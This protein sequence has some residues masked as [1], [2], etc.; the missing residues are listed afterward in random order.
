MRNLINNPSHRS[1]KFSWRCQRISYHDSHCPHSQH[2]GTCDLPRPAIIFTLCVGKLA[3]S[4]SQQIHIN[5]FSQLIV[6]T[7]IE[8]KTNSQ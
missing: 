1:V 5:I 3:K 6:D 4:Y 8:N 2:E 7:S